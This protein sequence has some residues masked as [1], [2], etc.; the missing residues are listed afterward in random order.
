M[1]TFF[2]GLQL[3][4][5]TTFTKTKTAPEFGSQLVYQVPSGKFAVVYLLNAVYRNNT[6]GFNEC[7]IFPDSL[8]QTIDPNN[9]SDTSDGVL[10]QGSTASYSATTFNQSAPVGK[11]ENAHFF[12]VPENALIA[13][14]NDIVDT[15]RVAHLWQGSSVVHRWS[16]NNGGDRTARIRI[17][18]FEYDLP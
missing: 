12:Q 13:E 17:L 8:E 2:G 18:V 4:R 9:F 5:I 3:S 6:T 15:I 1:A 16:I 11:G 14:T 10:L 7:R